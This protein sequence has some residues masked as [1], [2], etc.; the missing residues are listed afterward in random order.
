MLAFFNIGMTELLIV[1]FVVLLLFGSRLPSMMRSLGTSV[2]EFKKGM[3]DDKDEAD[4]A[5]DRKG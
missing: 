1:A 3:N 5:E 4:T 2:V